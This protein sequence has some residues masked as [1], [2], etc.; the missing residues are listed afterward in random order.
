MV[1]LD[2][3]ERVA[4]EAE[5]YEGRHGDRPLPWVYELD[6]DVLTSLIARARELEGLLK[7]VTEASGHCT[8]RFG[9][10]ENC[11]VTAL[12]RYKKALKLGKSK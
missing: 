1:D 9:P 10:H 8:E 11:T 5:P 7:E 4:Y 12:L 3:L 6:P 2:E